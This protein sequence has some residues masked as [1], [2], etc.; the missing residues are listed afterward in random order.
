VFACTVRVIQKISSA[1]MMISAM[2]TMVSTDGSSSA[3]PDRWPDLGAIMGLDRP[4]I[5][6]SCAA[7]PAPV[8]TCYV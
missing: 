3:D 6:A 7:R 2:P 5:K 8:V 1:E 4:E